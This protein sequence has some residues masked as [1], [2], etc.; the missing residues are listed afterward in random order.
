ME[1]IIGEMLV[2]EGVRLAGERRRVLER[3]GRAEGLELS[4]ALMLS[5]RA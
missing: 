2:D 3:K 1:S 4:D 5:L